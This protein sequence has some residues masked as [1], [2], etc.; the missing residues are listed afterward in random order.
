MDFHKEIMHLEEVMVL[1][2]IVWQTNSP[3]QTENNQAATK[4]EFH[5]NILIDKLTK[6]ACVVAK[7]KLNISGNL[8]IL[9]LI[10]YVSHK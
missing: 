1:D 5:I 3:K 9:K 10:F 7:N 8:D 6:A 4:Y 2:Y